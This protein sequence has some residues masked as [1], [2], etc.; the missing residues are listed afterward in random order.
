MFNLCKYFPHLLHIIQLV[1]LSM[2]LSS[3]NY[4][5]CTQLLRNAVS[6]KEH[7]TL[8][9][10]KHLFKSLAERC[11]QLNLPEPISMV[12]LRLSASNV[13]E[14]ALSIKCYIVIIICL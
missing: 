8:S 3:P 2:D 10:K 5:A 7:G 1:S 12:I 14:S 13:C 6:L 9:V 4:S 11:E